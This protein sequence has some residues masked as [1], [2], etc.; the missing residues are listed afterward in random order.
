MTG[1]AADHVKKSREQRVSLLVLLRNRSQSA[2]YAV[3]GTV[4]A[5]VGLLLGALAVAVTQFALKTTGSVIVTESFTS[6]LVTGLGVAIFGCALSA[7][8]FLAMRQHHRQSI[9]RTSIIAIATAGFAS[10]AVCG[11]ITQL[12]F[13]GITDTHDGAGPVVV[14]VASILV[15]ALLG[16]ALTLTVP[17]LP[18]LRGLLVGL[19][20]GLVSGFSSA[21]A[22]GWGIAAAGSYLFGFTVMGAALGFGIALIDKHFRDSVVEIEWGP[23]ATTRVGLGSKPVTIGGGKDHIVIP[24]APPHLSSI[25]VRNGQIEHVETSSDKR[26]E[27]KDG[28]RLRVAGVT[29]V[30]HKRRGGHR[31]RKS[32]GKTTAEGTGR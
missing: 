7:A 20:A 15:G 26:T 1:A 9:P 19:V 8:L 17:N 32:V 10:G 31:S 28:S 27:L 3:A 13:N 4:G 11:G 12:V 22:V 16:L 24:G 14:T 5:L 30:V 25:R 18:P 21:A 2:F 23:D 29:M 6:A